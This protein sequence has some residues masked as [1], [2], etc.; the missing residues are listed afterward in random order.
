MSRR[1]SRRAERTRARS[2]RDPQAPAAYRFRIDFVVAIALTLVAAVLLG[3]F[4]TH[5]PSLWRDEISSVHTQQAA[6]FAEMWRRAE[7]ESFPA[8]WMLLLRGWLAIGGGASDATLRVFGL[9][10]PVALI[11]GLWIATVRISRMAPVLSLS[12]VVINPDVL[13]WSA[14][15]RPWGLGAGLMLASTAFLWEA[16]RR[17]TRRHLIAAGLASLLSVHCLFQNAVFF[18]AVAA[19]CAAV[20]LRKGR[21]QLVAVPAAIGGI[22]AASLLPY[23]GQI[24]RRADWNPLGMGP[25]TIGDLA[26]V[27]SDTV[28]APGT[29]SWVVTV[30]LAA[31]TLLLAALAWRR[32]EP[33]EIGRPDDIVVYAGVTIVTAV[34]GLLLLYRWLCYPTQCWYYLGLIA[35]VAACVEVALRSWLPP[36]TAASVVGLAAGAVVVTGGVVVWGAMHERQTNLDVIAARL[37]AEAG[38]RD[39]VVVNPWFLGVTLSRYYGGPSPVMTIPPIADRTISRYDLLRQ[40]MLA[41]DATAPLRQAIDGALSTGHRVWIVGGFLVLPGDGSIPAT[42]PPPPLPET[43]WNSMPYELLWS[44]QVAVWLHTRANACHTL[45]PGVRGGRLEDAHLIVCSGWRH[46]AMAR[47]K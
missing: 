33:D 44:K 11:A 23:L 43:G 28:S 27:L 38:P 9:I 14:T 20:A 16:M 4:V 34:A 40:Q 15:L 35:L 26:S 39:L 19:G 36:R 46:A 24:Q 45:D 22:C 12:L 17:P 6:T 5:A 47:A 29:V 10:G 30:A 21:W 32:G 3:V 7:F 2:S 37:E 18:A 31:A 25:I 42:L 13:R 8:L 1:G 41:A